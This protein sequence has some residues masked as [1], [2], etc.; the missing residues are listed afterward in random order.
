MKIFNLLIISE[1]KYRETLDIKD[2]K[3]E[4]LNIKIGSLEYEKKRLGNIVAVLER[5]LEE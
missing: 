3:I 1:K 4:E 2:A 5:Y